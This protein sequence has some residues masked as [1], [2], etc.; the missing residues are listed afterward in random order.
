MKYE[1]MIMWLHRIKDELERQ[2][3]YAM[4]DIIDDAISVNVDPN[5]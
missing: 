2:E 3:Q 1:G 5:V 4:A